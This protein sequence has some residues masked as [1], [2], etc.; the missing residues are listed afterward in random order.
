MSTDGMCHVTSKAHCQGRLKGQSVTINLSDE[1]LR[2]HS[3]SLLL[4]EGHSNR[5]IFAAEILSLP[6]DLGERT[7]LV[8]YTSFSS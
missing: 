6:S 3:T 8:G 1:E 7:L 5:L 4:L 2:H